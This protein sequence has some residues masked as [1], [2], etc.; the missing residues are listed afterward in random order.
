MGNKS[1]KISII[2][3]VYNENFRAVDTIKNVLLNC[4]GKV[5]V[6]DDGSVDDTWKILNDS[7]GKDR[8]VHLLRHLINLGKGAAMKTGVLMAWKVKSDGVV[9]IDSDGQH[10]P[11]YLKKF[12]SELAKYDL[13]FGYRCL[14]GEMP[15]I[16]KYGNILAK[17]LVKVL[18]NVNRK[19][20]LCGYLGFRKSVYRLIKWSSPRYGVETE[21]ATKV[22][23][24][25]LLYKEVEI[26]TIYV[27]K[28]KGVS[29]IDA[30]KVLLKIPLW[31]FSK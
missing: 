25:N 29:L 16:R 28:Y 5:I 1:L 8:R 12:E 30:I 2:V 14:N 27:D 31:Y 20:F 6:V 22:G 23:R 13:V 26:D 3:P 10:N 4:T 19:E 24:N 15:F 18:F 17:A 7:F 21:I 9:F 11:K